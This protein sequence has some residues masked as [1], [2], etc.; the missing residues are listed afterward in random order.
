MGRSLKICGIKFFKIKLK[1]QSHQLSFVSEH[2]RY[3]YTIKANKTSFPP[4]GDI[5]AAKGTILN[6]F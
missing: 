4:A 1:I 2:L 5:S 3:K 6:V